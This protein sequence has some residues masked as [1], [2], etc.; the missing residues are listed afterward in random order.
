MEVRSGYKQTDVGVIPDDWSIETFGDMFAVGGGFSASWDQLSQKGYCYLH[1]GDIHK[2]AKT[3]IDVR[4]EYVDIPKL[5]I[6]LKRVSPKSLL[7][8][9]DVVF[10]DASEDDEGASKHVVVVNRENIP[11]I[12]GLHTIVAKSKK[13]NP[14]HGYRRYCFQTRD[15]KRQFYFYAVGTKVTGISKS[16]ITKILLPL[17]TPPEQRAIATAISDVDALINSLDRVIAK[18]R[19][20]KQGIIQ[21]LLTGKRRLP[22]FSGEWDKHVFGSIAV[23]RKEKV[24]P[25]KAVGDTFCVELEDIEQGSGRLLGNT[26]THEQ[27]SIKTA[28]Y[29][30]DVLF[31]KLRAYLKKYWLADRDGVCTTEIW[32]LVANSGVVESGYMYQIV[33]TEKFIE[34]ATMAYGT[35]MPRSDW[36]VV[37]NVW[38]SLP[39]LSEQRAIVTTLSD[40]DVEI[41]ALEH[42]RDKT[43]ALKQG[44]MQELLTGRTRLI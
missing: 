28:F 11:Y 32:P 4:S 18:K 12:S 8:D 44:M 42:K 15:V 23:P 40:M 37:K 14:D 9:G 7:N 6:A 31:G 17:P 34:A 30:G 5:D 35:H 26:I 38:I 2:S 20:F 21:E 39:S 16:N 1:Y 29:K 41:V 13:A 24:D 19:D 3:F 25:K 43:I 10:V 27:L 22:G 36:N 33:K